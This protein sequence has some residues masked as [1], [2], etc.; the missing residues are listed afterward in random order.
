MEMVGLVMNYDFVGGFGGPG[1][2]SFV[3]QVVDVFESSDGQLGQVLDVRSEQRVFSN[4]QVVLVLRVEQVSNP[5]T[6]DFH[7]AD[8]IKCHILIC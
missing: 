5:F 8:L 1:L 2:V 6:V 7:V 3:Y 4:P